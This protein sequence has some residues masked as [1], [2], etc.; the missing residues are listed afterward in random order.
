MRSLLPLLRGALLLLLLLPAQS[1]S[2]SLT[3]PAAAS[4]LNFENAGTCN[5]ACYAQ[6]EDGARDDPGD[7]HFLFRLSLGAEE[8]IGLPL[9]IGTHLF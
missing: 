6:S 5:V 4:S 9:G 2:R 3:A 8:H 1:S 7:R